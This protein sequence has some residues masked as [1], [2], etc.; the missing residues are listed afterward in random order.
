MTIKKVDS[1]Y[2]KE[3]YELEQKYLPPFGFVVS[4]KEL[5]EVLDLGLTW[6]LFEGDMLIGKAGFLKDNNG[7]Y[8]ID[9]IVVS[10]KFRRKGYGKLLLKNN[11]KEVK[12]QN[13]RSIYL[14]VHPQNNVAIILYLKNGFVIKDYIKKKYNGQDRLKMVYSKLKTQEQKSKLL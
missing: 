6:G 11:L 7:G 3:I 8:E 12:K 14:F 2:I 5:K 4:K 13:P 10:P 9:G 1:R